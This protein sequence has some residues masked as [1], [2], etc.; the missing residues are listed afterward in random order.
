MCA[1]DG[2]RTLD[3]NSDRGWFINHIADVISIPGSK[4]DWSRLRGKNH[5]LATSW[6][7]L[8]RHRVKNQIN[9]IVKR[10]NSSTSVPQFHPFCRKTKNPLFSSHSIK[11]I[12]DLPRRIE[13]SQQFSQSSINVI[14]IRMK[15]RKEIIPLNKSGSKFPKIS[16]KN[17]PLLL[18]PNHQLAR[19]RSIGRAPSR[20]SSSLPPQFHLESPSTPRTTLHVARPLS[21][22]NGFRTV[23]RCGSPLRRL[24]KSTIDEEANRIRIGYVPR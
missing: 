24:R 4:H 2:W 12:R 20:P 10:K 8:I 22:R 1:R 18:N 16:K 13:S 17:R 11:I 21:R 7:C 15:F 5:A 19:N 3:Y 9:Q 6:P 14:D 23:Y